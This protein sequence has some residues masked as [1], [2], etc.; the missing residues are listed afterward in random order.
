MGP[1]GL[2]TCSQKQ[3]TSHIVSQRNP[4]RPL[5]SL[6]TLL[7]KCNYGDDIE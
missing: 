6:F 7:D 4:E 1:K 2:F 3:A 5:S